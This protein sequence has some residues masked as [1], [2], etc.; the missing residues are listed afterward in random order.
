MT[1]YNLDKGQIILGYWNI[2]GLV[3]PSRLTLQYTK[4][5]YTDKMYQVGDAPE[6]NRDEW[7]DE[8]FKL[9]LDFPNLP[10][11]IDG[12]IKLT[13]SKAILYYLGRQKNLMGNNPQE[14]ALVTMLCEQAHDLRLEFGKFCFGPNGD[15]ESEKKKFLDTTVTEHIKQL[16]AYLGKNKSRFAV[17]DKPTVADFQLFEYVD[18]C[19]SIDGGSMLLEKYTN[20]KELLQ[21]VRELPELKDYIAKSHAQLPMHMKMAKF[22]GIVVEQK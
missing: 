13:Q 5:P 19:C 7:L 16:N 15:S 9:G 8:K 22:G 12:D 14:E 20:V 1:Q 21:E 2:R 4:T 6:Y 17:G 10:Y 3:E 18:C 11:L